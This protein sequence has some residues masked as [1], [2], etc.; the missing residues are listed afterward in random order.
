MSKINYRAYFFTKRLVIFVVKL[1]IIL[2]LLAVFL[3]ATSDFFKRQYHDV[4][5]RTIGQK[6]IRLYL[7]G[8]VNNPAAFWYSSLHY[9]GMGDLNRAVIEMN[10]AIS[11]LNINSAPQKT[12][13]PYIARIKS[14]CKR[15]KGSE[16]SE[17]RIKLY[18]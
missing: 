8:L 2:A 15:M 12:I 16:S 1:A 5:N 4:Y 13:E 9:E 10:Y 7:K 17:C 11:L 3:A 18:S 6:V 14:L